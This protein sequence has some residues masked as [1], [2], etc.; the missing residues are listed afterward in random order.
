MQNWRYGMKEYRRC[1]IVLSL[2]MGLI[3]L[4]FCL[5]V[6]A[7]AETSE[8]SDGDEKGIALSTTV[9]PS[10]ISGAG[11]VYEK[12][13]ASGLPFTTD[14]TT[15]NLLRVLVDGKVV[16]PDSYTVS[17]EPLTVTLHAG[18]LDTLFAGEHTI[19]IVT[20]NGSAFA[21]FLM[22]GETQKTPQTGDSSNITAW[23]LLLSFSFISIL[24]IALIKRKHRAY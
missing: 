23:I 13:G 10:V 4:A 22:S 9:P 20:V 5:P 17:G 21:K 11:A 1:R 24:I 6:C 3:L 2:L 16:S 15:G 7:F 8:L 18:Y 14:D 12:G 19:E